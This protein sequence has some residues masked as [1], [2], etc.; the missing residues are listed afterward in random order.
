MLIDSHAFKIAPYN[1]LFMDNFKNNIREFT[2]VFAKRPE[3]A[4]IFHYPNPIGI[5]YS[6]VSDAPC[7]PKGEMNPISLESVINTAAVYQS[8]ED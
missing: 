8:T 1:I 5:V 2:K 3:H 4:Y 7:Q 6:S